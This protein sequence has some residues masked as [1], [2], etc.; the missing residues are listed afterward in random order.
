MQGHH[1]T[2]ETAT[3]DSVAVL[4]LGV[5]LRQAVEVMEEMINYVPEYFQKKWN[6]QGD[7]DEAKTRLVDYFP[8]DES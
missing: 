2:Q 7:I 8:D 5:A 1:L 3:D 6:Y 4:M